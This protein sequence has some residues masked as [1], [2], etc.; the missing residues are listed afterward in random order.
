MDTTI[1]ILT[2]SLNPRNIAGP[3]TNGWDMIKNLE[4]SVSN[5]LLR[6]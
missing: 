5:V 1:G 6:H 4:V 3:I 2:N